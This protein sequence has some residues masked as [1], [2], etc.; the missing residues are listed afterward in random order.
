MRSNVSVEVAGSKELA[1]VRTGHFGGSYAIMHLSYVS[2]H[3]AR[4]EFSVA[5]ARTSDRRGVNAP[6][7]ITER[8]LA[9]KLLPTPLYITRKTTNNHFL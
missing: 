6:L 1:T 9:R 2:C 3:V 4:L 8:L 7:V 5:P